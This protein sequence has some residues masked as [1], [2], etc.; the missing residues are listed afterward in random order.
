MVTF[1]LFT[2]LNGTE[3]KFCSLDACITVKKLF[4]IQKSLSVY[5]L[6]GNLCRCTGY[7]PILHGYKTL[8]L[9][10]THLKYFVFRLN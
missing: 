3:Q 6:S 10:R 8:T 4:K 2:G 7:R 5:F 1:K 9:V